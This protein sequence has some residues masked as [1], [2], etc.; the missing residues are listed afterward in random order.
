MVISP[1]PAL[2]L[3]F[4]TPALSLG[5]GGVGTIR[6]AIPRHDT[7]NTYSLITDNNL[8]TF[9]TIGTANYKNTF[10]PF[11]LAVNELFV[12]TVVQT[13][14][15]RIT[16]EQMLDVDL[17]HRIVERLRAAARLSSLIV[18]DNQSLGITNLTANA[19]YG[20]VEAAPFQSISLTPMIGM[21]Y[22]YQVNQR[23]RGPSYLLLLSSD[24]LSYEGYNTGLSGKWQ[25][26]D[27]APRTIE[28]RYLDFSAEKT[29]FTRTRNLFQFHYARNKRDFYSPADAVIQ[30]SFGVSDNIESRAE[31][32][33]TISDFLDY[34]FGSDLLLRLQGI[35]ATRS[36][37]RETRYRYYA[38]NP[39]PGA[40]T[41]TQEVKF[42]GG[43]EALV[44]VGA[45]FSTSLRITYQERDEKHEVL[46]NDSLPSS[47]YD[48]Y[49]TLEEE[50]NNHSRRAWLSSTT[51]FAFSPSQS[52]TLTASTSL[53]RY[54]TPTLENDDDRDELAYI[55]S[56][57]Y[58][59]RFNTH[60][61]I[62]L[63]IDANLTHLVY[64][65]STRSA[66]NTWNR[67]FRLAPR[68]EYEPSEAV[69]TI[70]TFEVLANYT[71]YDFEYPSSPIRSF[72]FRQFGFT[73]STAVDIT[74]RFGFDF[75]GL[76]KLYERGELQWEEFEER[77]L[78]YFDERTYMGSVRYRLPGGLLFSVGIR[79]FNQSRY[80]YTGTERALDQRLRS[81]GPL[82]TVEWHV[83]RG[84]AFSL[85]GWYE[86][87]QQTG[88]PDRGVVTMTMSLIVHL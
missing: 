86:N 19:F 51:M 78:T 31:D 77:P 84:T 6:S 15:K 42:E 72:V 45:A 25:Y 26:D 85:R 47:T 7:L 82:T 52:M 67:I 53:L 17:R 37:D 18:S 48:K 2:F 87:Q 68:L 46:S 10:G 64:L 74:S 28:T 62:G 70:N 66:D 59:S 32:A 40:N 29:F 79:Y 81:I 49:S 21:R 30:S 57:L 36:I 1:S 83:G 65:P 34:G 76:V 12:S 33:F 4:I 3:L 43:A 14:Q 56:A 23:D 44:S 55:L 35:V 80:S 71:S 39:N 22:E 41:T 38:G 63:A 8:S 54:D 5:Q 88:A 61:G 11:F 13:D 69:T 24:S 27:L 75:F 9:R 50:R 58:Y 60:L 16:D 20:G 73:D